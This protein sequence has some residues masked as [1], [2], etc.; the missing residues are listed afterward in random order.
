MP[1]GTGTTATLPIGNTSR[2]TT[3]STVAGQ[4]PMASM[5]GDS[6]NFQRDASNNAQHALQIR[7]R[8]A[9]N[10][11]VTGGIKVTGAVIATTIDAGATAIVINARQ[12]PSRS[13]NN[14]GTIQ[15]TITSPESGSFASSVRD[16]TGTLTT[17]NNSGTISAT[18]AAPRTQPT[19]LTCGP[20]PPASPSIEAAPTNLAASTATATLS[21]ISGNIITGSG[22]DTINA[23]RRHYCQQCL[24]GRRQ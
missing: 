6:V 2:A 5:I 16:L 12:Q 13:S 4:P 11:A 8:L 20:I 23:S 1:S 10:V 3:L 19:H 22:N 15:A 21:G 17:I 18:G 24:H 7:L 9:G 14:T